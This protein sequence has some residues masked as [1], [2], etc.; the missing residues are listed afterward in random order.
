M[1]GIKAFSAVLLLTAF[2]PNSLSINID[3]DY[4]TLGDWKYLDPSYSCTITTLNV[5]RKS[6]VTSTSGTHSDGYSDGAVKVI[7]IF[8]KACEVIP[9]GVGSFFPSVEGF[10]VQKSQLKTITSADIQQFSNLRE[11]WL[12]DNNLEYLESNLFEFNPRVEY[13]NCASNN[14]K[15]IGGSFLQ[16]LP[17]LQDTTFSSNPC[18]S[19]A[20]LG[21]LQN[22]VGQCPLAGAGAF[23]GDNV[24]TI[25]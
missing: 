18:T 22:Q 1:I 13:I 17:S 21:D 15:Y 9:P 19:A 14:I 23:L 3:C 24:K 11:L 2:V 8:E 6:S 7:K 16:N 4:E 5:K 10:S 20:S 12:D 25:G